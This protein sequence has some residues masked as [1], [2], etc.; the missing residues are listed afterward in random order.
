MPAYLKMEKGFY[1]A[2][3]T[4][5]LPIMLQNFMNQTMQLLDTFMVGGLGEKE[6][7]AVTLANTPFFV[8]MLIVFGLQSGSSVLFS[9]YWGKNDTVTIN[10]V[11]GIGFYLSGAITFIMALVVV[12]YPQQVMSITTNDPELIRIGAEYARV[13][14][15]S[16]FI[17]SFAQIYIAAQRCMENAKL[18]MYILSG[19]IIINTFLNWVLIFGKFGAPKMGVA[20]A[21]L[22]TVIARFI[23]L[24]I[25]VVYASRCKRFKLKLSVM[26]HPGKLIFS[27]FLRYSAPVVLNETLWGIGFSIYPVIIGH[28]VNA[29]AAVSAYTISGNI[30]RLLSVFLFAVGNAAAVIIGK[31]L[32]SG[33]SNPDQVFRMGFC[34]MMISIYGGIAGCLLICALNLTVIGPYILPL[35]KL[36]EAS[37]LAQTMLYITALGMPLRAIGTTGIV[38]VLRGGGDV[39]AALLFDTLPMYFFGIPLA[40]FLGLTLHMSVV[41]VYVVMNGE[42]LIKASL[43]MWRLMSRKW[44][45][46]VTRDMPGEELPAG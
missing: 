3:I 17:N 31:A 42:E 32:G 10:R 4:L 18:G 13:V 9:Q 28:L 29:S 20:G 15:F 12:I 5:T 43:I 14:A 34:L 21:A 38:G 44:I 22:A 36:N 39:R 35:F 2:L 30:E 26:L 45:R 8:M 7:A 6:L 19:S 25:T 46:N 1:K 27:D 33:K 37:G 23:E 11:I 40:A 41:W 24:I 16:Y